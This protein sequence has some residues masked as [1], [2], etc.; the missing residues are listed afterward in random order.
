MAVSISELIAKK[1]DLRAKRKALYDLETSLG[2]FTVR[3]PGKS[4]MLEAWDLEEGGDSY[5]IVNCVV[6]PDLK[7]SQLP[8]VQEC[9]DYFAYGWR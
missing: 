8:D 4:L 1:D 9:F 3:A 6:E 2:T 5:L 7:D